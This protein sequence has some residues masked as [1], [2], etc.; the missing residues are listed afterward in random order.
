MPAAVAFVPNLASM[1]SGQL[2]E[3]DLA[4]KDTL[5]I[6][7]ASS[8]TAG[9]MSHPSISLFES[10]LYLTASLYHSHFLSSPEPLISVYPLRELSSSKALRYGGT[11]MPRDT[12]LDSASAE[13]SS[14]QE[15]T[16]V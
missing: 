2:L 16:T 5:Y 14:P 7:P 8:F 10:Y 11:M 9:V 1:R 6:L 13:T 3:L 15:A 12:L 4:S